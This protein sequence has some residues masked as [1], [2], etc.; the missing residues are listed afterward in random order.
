[1]LT[2]IAKSRPRKPAGCDVTSLAVSG[3]LQYATTYCTKV[4]K[5]VAAGIEVHNSVTV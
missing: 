4:L 2:I 3:R 1:M 5:T